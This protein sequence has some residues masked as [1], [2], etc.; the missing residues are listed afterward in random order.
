MKEFIVPIPLFDNKMAVNAYQLN[1]HNEKVF[2]TEGDYQRMNEACYSPGLDIVR[3]VGLEP[4]AGDK[5]LFFNLTS[6]QLFAGVPADSGFDPAKMV[7]ILDV[8][9]SRDGDMLARIA[10]LYEQGYSFALNAYPPEGESHPAVPYLKY[11]LI[12]YTAKPFFEWY[13]A[14]TF[15]NAPLRQIRPVITHIPDMDAFTS[16]RNDTRSLFTGFFYS[17]PITKGNRVISPIRVN[18]LH[19]LNRV[20]QEDFDLL[21][22]VAIIERD[23]YLSLSLLR[24]INSGVA[25]LG[26]R[27]DSIQSA[28]AILGQ[29]EVRHWATVALSVS[30][31]EDRPSEITRLSLVR[32]K[33]AENLAPLFHFRQF[34]DSF[35]LAG[36]FSLIDII[37]Q[38]PMEEA[39]NELALDARVREMLEQEGP[40]RNVFLLMFAYERAEWGDA[41]LLMYRNNIDI[42]ALQQAYTG[43]LVWY[44]QLL[45]SI[46]RK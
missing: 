24:F 35:F 26:R 27:I 39:L 14:L 6:F 31:A 22:V 40:F 30:L 41:A 21:D 19:L 11:M 5:P 38:K 10:T 3:E 29:K 13:R 33:F 37:L 15:L 25:G 32:A 4:F 12:D 46:D 44:R 23:P 20:Q 36:L 1:Y 2:G 16:F 18:V 43:A 45:V 34:K 42:E 28:V 8:A 17:Q 9:D 7:A